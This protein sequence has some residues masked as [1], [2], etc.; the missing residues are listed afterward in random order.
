MDF[1]LGVGEETVYIHHA[2]KTGNF[3]QRF[4]SEFGASVQRGGMSSTLRHIQHVGAK[5]SRWRLREEI[6]L[7]RDDC[8]AL[9]RSLRLFPRVLRRSLVV[10]Q[11][12]C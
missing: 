12:E 6:A 5:R 10:M 11:Q 7:P 9:A 4:W 2:P 1:E 8:N 3:M